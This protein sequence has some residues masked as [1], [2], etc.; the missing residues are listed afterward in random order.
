[1]E[2]SVTIEDVIRM[3]AE[4][5]RDICAMPVQLNE[6]VRYRLAMNYRTLEQC[7]NA[8]EQSKREIEMSETSEGEENA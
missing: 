4:S 5:I 2:H 6:D 8:I 3:T 1:M 7:L